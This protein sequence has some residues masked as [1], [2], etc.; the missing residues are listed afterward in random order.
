[1]LNK[2]VYETLISEGRRLGSGRF[3]D[4]SFFYQGIRGDKE[5]K[6]PTLEPQEKSTGKK[7][8]SN[9]GL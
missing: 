8:T 2:A 5:V 4:E 9:N 1:M 7:K 6:I 3:L